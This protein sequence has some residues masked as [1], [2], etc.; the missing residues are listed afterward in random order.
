MGECRYSSIILDLG[1]RWRS[2]VSSTPMS[3]YPQGRSPG[4][5]WV[6]PRACLGAVEKIKGIHW[7]ESNSCPQSVARYH[8]LS[9]RFVISE[10]FPNGNR[11]QTTISQG[12]GE[13][14]LVRVTEKVHLSVCRSRCRESNPVIFQIQIG[15][16]NH[17]TVPWCSECLCSVATAGL[18]V[19]CN[20]RGSAVASVMV[21][22]VLGHLLSVGRQTARRHG[23]LTLSLSPSQIISV[24]TSF[25]FRYVC[26]PCSHSSVSHCNLFPN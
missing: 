24:A 14:Y 13:G 15:D 1:P 3:L 20:R 22:T 5:H 18:E 23:L 25:C 10:L 4:T 21:H 6:G 11:P 17:C 7:Q 8:R 26:L 16:G 19:T 9:I 12:R 2:M